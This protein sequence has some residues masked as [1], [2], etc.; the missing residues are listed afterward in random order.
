MAGSGAE[1]LPMS[2]EPL[3]LNAHIEQPLVLADLMAGRGSGIGLDDWEHGRLEDVLR[4]A[5]MELGWQ[6]L[7]AALVVAYVLLR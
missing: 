6:L 7:A 4:D 5:T 1:N 3:A 2:G